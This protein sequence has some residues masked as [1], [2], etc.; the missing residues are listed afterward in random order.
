M[1]HTRKCGGNFDSPER[2][3]SA[4][5]IMV[6]VSDGFLIQHSLYTITT[7]KHVSNVTIQFHK[8]FR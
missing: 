7:H 4:F 8:H 5:I 1:V 6:N 3:C 2:T